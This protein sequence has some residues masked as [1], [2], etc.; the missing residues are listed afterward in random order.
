MGIYR[1][2]GSLGFASMAFFSGSIADRTSLRLPIALA[3]AFLA[4]AFVLSLMV[5]EAPRPSHPWERGSTAAAATAPPLGRRLPLIP[6]L[7]SVFLWSLAFSAVLSVWSIYMVGQLNYSRTAMSRLWALAAF[8][9]FPM[10]V[11]AGWL[12][13]RVGR[14]PMLG[15][16]LLS[17]VVVFSCYVLVPVYPWILLVQVGRGFAFGAFV[18]TSMTYAT[19][20]TTQAERGRASGVYSATRGL[21]AVLGGT[22][23]GLLTQLLG[24]R[25][26]LFT[27]AGLV[28][29]GAIYVAAVYV[30][31]KGADRAPI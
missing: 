4:L 10:M 1:G 6:L 3:A 16:G 26:M 9:E 25:F 2:L 28:F 24:F 5:R 27:C 23:G 19:E 30:R 17:W 7:V 18:G 20:V 31:W 11:L 14:L 8:T 12:S 22:V 21:G 29:G 13:D 15:V